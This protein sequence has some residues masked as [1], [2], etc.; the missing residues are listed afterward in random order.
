MRLKQSERGAALLTVMMI[1]AAM[2]VAALAV[3]RNVTEASIRSQALDAQAQ[4]AFYAVS[5]EEVA[6]AQL[7]DVLA[8]LEN[9]LHLDLPGLGEPQ[10]IPI[11]DGAIIVTVRDASNCFD[12]NT[13]TKGAEG[14]VQV[15]DPDQQAAYLSVL[16]DV[17]E[18]GYTS[19]LTALV[20]SLSD[21][22][23]HNSVPGNGGAEDSY[24]LSEVPSYR[25]SSQPL[26]SLDEL[27]SIRGYTVDLYAR[28]R[29]VVCARPA[30]TQGRFETLNINTLE[31]HHAPLLRQAFAESITLDE[32]RELIASRPPGGWTDVEALLEEPVIN[33]VNPDLVRKD[34]L[35]TVTSLV[36]VS[37]NVAYR[38]HDM[39]M[40]YLFEA[41]PGRP[42]RTLQRERIG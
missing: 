30:G 1:V 29:P 8:P 21:W 37:A 12:V 33:R 40:R 35:S 2:S 6:K 31:V 15:A 18:D 5:A 10:I 34:R 13:L 11:D 7:V 25:T 20:S 19:D 14:G 22:M 38:G 41:Q 32:A 28:L 16:T 36:E 26:A 27:R 39:T 24:Y 3:T 17:I 9:K 23:D 42:V 4:L